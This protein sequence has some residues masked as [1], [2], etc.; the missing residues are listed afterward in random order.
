M[1]IDWVKFAPALLLILLPIGLF[2]GKKTR[3]RYIS[4]EWDDHWPQ[5]LTLGLHW[6]DLG[7]AIIGAWWLSESLKLGN[8]AVGIERYGVPLI[9]ATVF[10]LGVLLQTFVCKERDSANA[11]FMFVTGLALG[12][13]APATA[14]FPILLALTIA[15][16]ARSPVTYF[17]LLAVGVMGGG[18]V[19]EGKPAMLKICLTA[20]ALMLPWLL[21][22]MFG[23]DLVITYRAKRPGK[24]GVA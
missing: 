19:F 21:T 20:S 18:Y 3:F 22:L 13:Y 7:R 9:T 6:I 4:R 23:R 16:G 24:D 11:P 14:G 1:I 2:H 15:C 17:P 8:S 5:I 10:T 12:F